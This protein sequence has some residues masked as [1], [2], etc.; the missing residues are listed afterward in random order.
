MATDVD[1]SFRFRSR[2]TSSS[3]D[4]TSDETCCA[5]RDSCSER[6]KDRMGRRH[7][8][9]DGDAGLTVDERALRRVKGFDWRFVFADMATIEEG[10]GEGEI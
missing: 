7:S 4:W 9:H 1:E 2:M 10:W 3:R 6:N 5:S 8:L